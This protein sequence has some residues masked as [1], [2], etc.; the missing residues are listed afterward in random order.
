MEQ[1]QNSQADQLPP[2]A[3]ACI[4]ELTLAL[5]Y[6]T[7]FKWDKADQVARASWRGY[8]WDAL[9]HLLHSDD[10]SGCDRKAVWLSDAGMARARDIL[11]KYGMPICE[12]NA[13]A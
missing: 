6:L 13:E 9:E 12:E 7:R 3:D 11:K 2:A 5:L 1:E 4:E 10:L 8:D